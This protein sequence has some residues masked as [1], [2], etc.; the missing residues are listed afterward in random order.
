MAPGRWAACGINAEHQY[1]AR[2]CAAIG[3]CSARLQGSAQDRGARRRGLPGGCRVDFTVRLTAVAVGDDLQLAYGA[4]STLS[5]ERTEPA[6]HSHESLCAVRSHGACE[7]LTAGCRLSFSNL[8]L[9]G[10]FH[11]RTHAHTHTHTHKL[12]S[13]RFCLFEG[14]QAGNVCVYVY[15]CMCVC[16]RSLSA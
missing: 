6:V 14:Q 8:M 9:M 2:R 16:A 5:R 10:R 3:V 12:M 7:I 11:T 15:G 1:I 13:W 4:C